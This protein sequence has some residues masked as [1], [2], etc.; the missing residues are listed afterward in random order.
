MRRP[1]SLLAACVVPAAVALAEPSA[2]PTLDGVMA[3]MA[4]ARGVVARFEETKEV[5][6]LRTPL[7]SRGV[8]HFVPPDRM[9]RRTLEPVASELVIDGDRM[10]YRDGAR[11]EPT[12]LSGEP[13][14]LHFAANFV[15]LFGGDLEALEERYETRFE[16]EGSDWSLHLVP[17]D[18][19]VRRFVAELA[20][21][22]DGRVMRELAVL[23][24][25]GDRTITRFLEVDADHEHSPEELRE[26]FGR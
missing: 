25:D 6:L 17:R 8:L 26:L 14:A 24:A 16:A 21:R 23:E 2:P 15:V 9:V 18:G 7:S 13:A 22:G 19:A 4:S 10:W 12:D 1:A 5:A 3:G 20:L 11:S